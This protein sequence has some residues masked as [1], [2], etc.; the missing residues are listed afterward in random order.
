[1]RRLVLYVSFLGLIA[2]FT[3]LSAQDRVKPKAAKGGKEFGQPWAE[4]SATTTRCNGSNSTTA[5][6]RRC[7]A[8][9]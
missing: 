3:P 1:M 5:S 2:L 9:C 6:I 8:S 4:V 7:R